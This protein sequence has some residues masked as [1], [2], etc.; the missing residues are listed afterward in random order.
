MSANELL[1]LIYNVRKTLFWKDANSKVITQA[2]RK[3]RFRFLN[4]TELPLAIDKLKKVNAGLLYDKQFMGVS[5][6]D[7]ICAVAAEP[8]GFLLRLQNNKL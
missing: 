7:S 6:H 4:D 3:E 5:Q 2:A 8:Y 1:S